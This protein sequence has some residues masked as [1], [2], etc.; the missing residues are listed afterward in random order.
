MGVKIDI[1]KTFY[2]AVTFFLVGFFSVFGFI[3]FQNDRK[4][5]ALRNELDKFYLNKLE[6][7]H[8]SLLSEGKKDK[9][10]N[11]LINWAYDWMKETKEHMAKDGYNWQ[12]IENIDKKAERNQQV[13]ALNIDEGY[14]DGLA[15]R[16]R[17]PNK[18]IS[19]ASFDAKSYYKDTK[20]KTSIDE[21][22]EYEYGYTEGNKA[23]L[24]K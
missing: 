9:P 2:I 8:F 3:K 20:V 5:K 4:E 11:Q 12:Q 15:G 7:N 24:N 1:K 14:E 18:D 16:P 13:K 10:N 19:K 22:Y 21:K 23:R 6:T 17:N